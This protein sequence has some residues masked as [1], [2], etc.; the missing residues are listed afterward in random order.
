MAGETASYWHLIADYDW[1]E[2]RAFRRQQF[3]YLAR[4]GRQDVLAWREVPVTI[5]NEAYRALGALVSEENDPMKM[6]DR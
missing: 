1:R 3:A 5:L 6:E 4:Y 2:L